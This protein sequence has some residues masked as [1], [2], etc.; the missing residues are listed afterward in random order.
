M[1]NWRYNE[2]TVK[3]ALRDNTGPDGQLDS[4]KFAR[5]LLLLR[6]TP[7]RETGKSPAELLLGRRLRDALPHPYGRRQS[8]ISN[9]S[10][11]DKRWLAMWSEKEQAM[12]IRMGKMVDQIDAKAHDLAPLEVG[13][14]VRVQNQTGTHKT[15]WD[16]TGVVMEVNL[17]YDQYLVKM[18]GSRRTTSRNRKFL[19]AIRADRAAPER[20]KEPGLPGPAAP[21]PPP[22]AQMP[23]VPLGQNV[24]PRGGQNQA[25]TP[26]QQQLPQLQ[27]PQ[28]PPQQRQQQQ[29]PPGTPP[30][31]RDREPAGRGTRRWHRR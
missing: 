5:A 8:L 4:D 6:N 18:D 30:G 1:K 29:P 20:P 2:F 14:R 21:P 17:P 15:R 19:R 16:R 28:P 27:Q 12:R 23:A 3:R 10:P 26:P 7:D 11:I 24:E 25:H 22:A 31:R 9:D 13:T